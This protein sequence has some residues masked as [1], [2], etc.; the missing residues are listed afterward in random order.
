M[1]NNIK[2]FIKKAWADT[3]ILLIGIVLFIVAIVVTSLLSPWG[4]I[5]VLVYAFYKKTIGHGIRFIGGLLK[6][7]AIVVDMLANVIMQVPSNR[8][9]IKPEGHQFGKAGETY[10][11]VLGTNI[12][13]NTY[14]SKGLWI[15]KRLNFFDKNHCIK[16]IQE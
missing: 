2:S 13:D 1:K 9:L 15:C 8:L 6:I 5:E 14:L 4:I 12:R 11:D 3:K 10:S 16:S 7:L